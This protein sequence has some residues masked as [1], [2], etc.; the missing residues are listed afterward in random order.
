A[1]ARASGAAAHPSASSA[2]ENRSRGCM[3]C[4]Q[5]VDRGN[6]GDSSPESPDLFESYAPDELSEGENIL[7]R[8][9]ARDGNRA[10]SRDSW[11]E[12]LKRQP[13]ELQLFNDFT[14]DLVDREMGR[15]NDVRILRDNERR[16]E[17]RRI[18]KIACGDFIALALGSASL[19]AHVGRCVDVKF[20][21]RAWKNHRTDVTALDN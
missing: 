1:L 21:G 11:I 16:G 7:D 6:S 18:G 19:E 9:S 17:P 4:R 14:D 2:R 10:S 20:V 3:R 5:V 8:S 13:F 12:A 15:I